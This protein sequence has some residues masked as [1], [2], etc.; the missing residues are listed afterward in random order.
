MS[1][2][3]LRHIKTA[4]EAKYGPLVDMADYAGKPEDE[5]AM[6]MLSRAL[7]AFA[8]ESL[9][10]V[11]PAAAAASLVDGFNDN[12]IDA[13]LYE[14][15]EKTLYVVQS[16]WDSS[17]NSSPALGDLQKFVQGFRDLIDMRFDRFNA[18]VRAQ[19]A[20]LTSA[21]DDTQV[22]FRLVVV[23]TGTQELSEHGRRCLT[24]LMDELNDT[25]EIVSYQVLRQGDVHA[26]VAGQAEGAGVSF[27]VALRDWGLVQEPYVAY[28]GQIE[29]E[30]LA[31]WWSDH[32]VRLFAKNL[33][34]FIGDSDVN[35]SI[36]DTLAKEPENFWYFNNG[37]TVLCASV[38]KKPI[39]GADRRSGQFRC[40]GV[41]IVNGAQTV[42][43]I[44]T[45]H[46]RNADAVAKARV[47]V[48]FISLADCPPEFASAVTRATNTQNRIERRD[49][50]SLDKEQERLQ[51]ELRL[52][53]RMYALKTGEQDPLPET[54]CS[55]TEAT[56]ALACALPDSGLAVQAKREIGR[57]WENIE[58]PPYRLIF[59]GS[60]TGLKL[61][62]CVD[63]MR[64]VDSELRRIQETTEGRVRA[65]AVHGNRLILH[66]V[67]QLLP[68]ADFGA[69]GHDME[70]TKEKAAVETPMQ[71]QAI[72]AQVETEYP[73]GYVASLF[74]NASKCKAI[75]DAI[76][77][78]PQ[79]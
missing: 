72:A 33:R 58:R 74:K 57:L 35:R 40:E 48:R 13:L 27:D 51:T 36:E 5:S 30:D 66:S 68:I 19:R 64:V 31:A 9:A 23:H 52:E 3:H 14:Q 77:V 12:G 69:P 65:V 20:T 67:M 47:S 76:K 24:D 32:G 61:W 10:Q 39:G 46:E 45:A 56:V 26:L 42:G 16:K 28:Y 17:G 62:R 71:F 2:I 78:D 25:S 8:L 37:V 38:D 43:C 29:A 60:V 15:D 11:D 63:V 79:G 41:S 59:N 18:K 4:L 44:G 75:V 50:V 73:G 1:V 49:F 54:G 53:G 22:K 7:G 21:L 70:A 55:V 34:K 6:A